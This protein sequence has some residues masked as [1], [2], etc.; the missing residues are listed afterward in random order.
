MLDYYFKQNMQ[1]HILNIFIAIIILS[2]TFCSGFAYDQFDFKNEN[3]R[4]YVAQFAFFILSS[5]CLGSLLVYNYN[6]WMA[7]LGIALSFGVFKT[8]LLANAP[9]A[10]MFESVAIGFCAFIIYYV[11]RN[12]KLNGDIL[13]WFL[14]PA[15]LNIL[16][17]FIQRF[18]HYPL[19]FLY[20]K[21]VSGLI[22]SEGLSA[23]YL[24]LTLPLFIKYLRWG[25]IPCIVAIMACNGALGLIAGVA[26]LLFYLFFKDKRILIICCVVTILSLLFFMGTPGLKG[27]KDELHLRASMAV[28]TLDGIKHN[29]MLGWGVG[30]FL[31]TMAK[32][33]PDD[34]KFLQIKAQ[35]HILVKLSFLFYSFLFYSYWYP[36]YYRTVWVLY[37][38]SCA[39]L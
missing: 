11:I 26:G 12:L 24:A 1:K 21:G 10:E 32:I 15:V 38:E 35:N 7:Y 22:G 25:A 14:V 34:T 13:K 39:F 28:G 16:V 5:G 37:L 2:G 6:R 33:P 20:V 23:S 36:Y 19:F 18:D 31:P 8:F 9:R 30:S 27:V 3:G 29:P 17:I 4:F